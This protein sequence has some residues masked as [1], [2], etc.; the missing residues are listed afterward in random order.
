MATLIFGAS[1]F[2]GSRIL[3]FLKIKGEFISIGSNSPVRYNDNKNIIRNYHDLNEDQL[4]A[5]LSKYDYVIDASGISSNDKNIKTLDDYLAKN[6]LWPYKLAKVCTKTKSRLVWFSTVHC[7]KYDKGEGFSNNKDFYSISKYFGEV[8]IKQINN[9][10][11]N[12]LILRLG[13]ILGAPGSNFQGIPKLFAID[14][15]FNLVKNKKAIIQNNTDLEINI[16]TISELLNLINEKQN[17][18]KRCVSNHNYRLTEVAY[19]IK[20]IYETIE[21]KKVEI[22]YKSKKLENPEI[23][24]KIPESIKEEI[25]NLIN[26][27]ISKN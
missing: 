18:F 25:K 19:F 2:L 9:W 1:G 13:N 23:N 24:T 21:N 10:E 27:F 15:A 26:Y 17:G 5:I 8:L 22:I 20:E 6:S 14:M 4:E 3:D 11:E 12:I 16:T 7:D